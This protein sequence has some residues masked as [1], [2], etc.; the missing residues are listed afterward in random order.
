MDLSL[1]FL[2]SYTN[3]ECTLK[4]TVSEQNKNSLVIYCS[5]QLVTEQDGLVAQRL[6]TLTGYIMYDR[7]CHPNEFPTLM[8]SRDGWRDRLLNARAIARPNK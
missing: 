5:G 1:I 4:N 8:Q 2:R 7:G 3:A 6:P